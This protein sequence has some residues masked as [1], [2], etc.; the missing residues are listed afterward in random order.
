MALTITLEDCPASMTDQAKLNAEYRFHR[1]LERQLGSSNLI[2]QTYKAW[3]NAMEV[4]ES[5]LSEPDKTLALRWIDAV[6][7]A[8]RE[9][10]KELEEC[11][12][13]FDIH[14]NKY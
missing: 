5:E 6:T 3:Q 9:G 8:Q 4:D 10:L 13:Y 1:V 2:I 14:I 11:E 12:A 7:K